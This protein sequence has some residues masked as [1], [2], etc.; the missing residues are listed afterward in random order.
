M[1]KFSEGDE[2]SSDSLCC[3]CGCL[4]VFSFR[5]FGLADYDGRSAG[6]RENDA[7]ITDVILDKCVVIIN[8][9]IQQLTFLV[10]STPGG[11]DIY[12]ELLV[13]LCAIPSCDVSL[14]VSLYGYITYRLFSS[15]LCC[16]MKLSRFASSALA[17]T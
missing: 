5:L 3:G 8:I 12:K 16:V 4:F 17:N 1:Y 2:P 7:V 13:D 14:I 11:I 6:R 9:N 15:S 10:R